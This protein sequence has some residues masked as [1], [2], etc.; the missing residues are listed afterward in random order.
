[1]ESKNSERSQI[2]KEYSTT[3]KKNRFINLKSIKIIDENQFWK[4]K[5]FWLAHSL[6]GSKWQIWRWQQTQ[7]THA[8]LI[9][10]LNAHF[11][12]ANICTV[13]TVAVYVTPMCWHNILTNSPI[14]NVRHTDFHLFINICANVCIVHGQ[15]T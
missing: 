14:L 9:F 10:F 8:V 12:C 2:K 1:M 15:F 11:R 5:I 7:I 3:N 4:S 13:N 6:L